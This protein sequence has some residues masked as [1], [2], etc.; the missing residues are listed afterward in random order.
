MVFVILVLPLVLS[1]MLS[2][3]KSDRKLNPVSWKILMWLFSLLIEKLSVQLA[4]LE[5]LKFYVAELIPC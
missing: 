2:I 1:L 5:M 4:L 3:W